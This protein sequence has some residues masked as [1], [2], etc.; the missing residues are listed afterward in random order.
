MKAT[1]TSVQAYARVAIEGV[2]PYLESEVILS[3]YAR[4]TCL[5]QPQT[6]E[7]SVGIFIEDV[8]W[9]SITV[10]GM[11][12]GTRRPGQLTRQAT[13]KLT[14]NEEGSFDH[15]PS[16]AQWAL[17]AVRRAVKL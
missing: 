14:E 3:S 9:P 4:V 6:A 5:F 1:V 11:A 12:E 10:H 8:R 2:E 13:L 16:Y 17:A 7:V 15:W